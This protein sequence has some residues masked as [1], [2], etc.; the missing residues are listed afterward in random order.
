[1]DL[2][3]NSIQRLIC[4]K[5]QPANQPTYFSIFANK[6]LYSVSKVS[7][8]RISVTSDFDSLKLCHTV[9]FKICAKFFNTFRTA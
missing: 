5:I 2:A 1:M 6:A 7:E 3:L 4:H 9:T 8:P